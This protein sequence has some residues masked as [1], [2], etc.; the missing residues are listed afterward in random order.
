MSCH[1]CPTNYMPRYSTVWYCTDNLTSED[2]NTSWQVYARGC[3]CALI[4]KR[5]HWQPIEQVSNNGN[6]S[7]QMKQRCFTPSPARCTAFKTEAPKVVNGTSILGSLVS[8]AV[9]LSTSKKLAGY[10]PIPFVYNYSGGHPGQPTTDSAYL[11]KVR[12]RREKLAWRLF[13]LIL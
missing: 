5:N 7:G 8:G 2:Q 3:S 4:I 12:S 11:G 10:R 9:F 1:V 13:E 6:N